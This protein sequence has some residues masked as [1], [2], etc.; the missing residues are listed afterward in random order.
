MCKP[1]LLPSKSVPLNKIINV[2]YS[3]S[4]YSTLHFAK[5]QLLSALQCRLKDIGLPMNYEIERLIDVHLRNQCG[6][7]VRVL[8]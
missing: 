3:A 7:M 1:V 8:F 6:V 4:H 2:G 5:K